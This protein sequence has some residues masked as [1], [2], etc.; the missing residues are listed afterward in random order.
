MKN[1]LSIILMSLGLVLLILGLGFAFRLS[2]GGF[3]QD[4]RAAKV[5]ENAIIRV[6]FPDPSL[7][8]DPRLQVSMNLK[9]I[10]N[11]I[12]SRLVRINDVGEIEPDLAESWSFDLTRREVI[13]KLRHNVTFHDGSIVSAEDVIFSF[14]NWLAPR[15]LDNNLLFDIDGGEAYALG[16]SS[17]IAG[18]RKI[19][20]DTIG[21]RLVKS[22]T[23]DFMYALATPRFYVFKV[24]TSVKG[25]D[26][27]GSGPFK[28][29][30]KGVQEVILRRNENYYGRRPQSSELIFYS[31]EKEK[32]ISDLLRGES[33]ALFAYSDF[34]RNNFSERNVRV[35]PIKK[36]TTGIL[37][38]MNQGEGKSEKFRKAVT[39]LF[40]RERL[41]EACYPEGSLAARIIPPGLRGS[42]P[43]KKVSQ[44]NSLV[45]PP[46]ARLPIL[47]STSMESRCL[48]DKLKENYGRYGGT[49]HE[50][51][52]LEELYNHFQ[53]GLVNF[54]FERLTFKSLD[55]SN[56]LQY[57]NPSSAEYF[58]KE[59]V[60]ELKILFRQLAHAETSTQK[61]NILSLIDEFLVESSFV[62]PLQHETFY[63]AYS[64]DLVGFKQADF[65]SIVGVKWEELGLRAAQ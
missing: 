45:L 37:F 32:A 11:A 36:T 49:L 19:G 7:E 38:F 57:F 29:Y 30:R 16:R 23:E 35:I 44:I 4:N 18:L 21:V 6:P 3:A 50:F 59:E 64:Q 27:L 1:S 48:F 47:Y 2:S 42:V 9:A 14:R 53:K 63:T 8:V 61:F 43:V 51:A 22:F 13:I 56:V 5:I 31:R 39:G 24:G 41:R 46:P 58:L 26:F 60:P 55:P 15:A 54:A 34:P 65:G 17:D 28:V 10:S 25:S 40:Q 20:P 33:H 62:I 12:F 52:S